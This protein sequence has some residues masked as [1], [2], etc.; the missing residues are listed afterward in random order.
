MALAANWL[1]A[2]KNN[3][4]ERDDELLKQINGQGEQTWQEF[5]E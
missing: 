3:E 5:S 4:E 2:A 1:I